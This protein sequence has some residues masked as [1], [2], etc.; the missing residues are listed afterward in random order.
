MIKDRYLIRLAGDIDRWIALGYVDAKLRDKLLTEAGRETP[1][2][3][4]SALAAVAATLLGLALIAFISA[5]WNEISRAARIALLVAAFWTPLAAAT[6]LTG[7][8]HTWLRDSAVL[9]SALAF[10]AA[11]GLMGQVLNMPGKP[12]DAF[13][14]AALAALAL[15]LSGTS[16]LTL[17]VSMALGLMWQVAA[18]VPDSPWL[19]GDEWRR[20]TPADGAAAGLIIIGCAAAW[21]WSSRL[22]SH[23]GV[24]SFSAWTMLLCAKFAFAS[25]EGV[26]LLMLCMAV[27]GMGAFLLGARLH[28]RGR[29]FGATLQGYGALIALLA[30]FIISLTFSPGSDFLGN[31]VPLP[32]AMAV[33]A[34]SL[35][36]AVAAV[37]FGYREKHTWILALG[38][39]G[40][41]AA[42]GI[43]ITDLG[44]SLL[45]TSVIFLIGAVITTCMALLIRKRRVG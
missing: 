37:A 25:E 18:M 38:V 41:I 28:W 26:R 20:L 31:P 43:L 6:A 23:V 15:S 24:L 42:I 27:L 35:V 10:T 14:M 45:S 19:N 2:R 8:S 21:S 30:L 32:A 40:L 7:R 33:R 1:G 3:A 13:M 22:L 11:V 12:A 17:A 39:L 5:N 29:P 44:F 34:C 4:H 16:R 36:V 9:L